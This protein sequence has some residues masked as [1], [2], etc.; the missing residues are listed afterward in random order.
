MRPSSPQQPARIVHS[1]T[2]CGAA[3]APGAHGQVNQDPLAAG[4]GVPRSPRRSGPAAKGGGR[5]RRCRAR[6]MFNHA[7]ASLQPLRAAWKSC[8]R[9][10]GW[11]G[12]RVACGPRGGI[13]SCASAAAA[14]AGGQKTQPEAEQR[15]CAC[16]HV[17]LVQD[18]AQ[19]H[20]WQGEGRS[21]LQHIYYRP[22]VL[23]FVSTEFSTYVLF[24]RLRQTPPN[25]VPSWTATCC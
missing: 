18:K 5:A 9:G 24:S 16:A 15:C 23:N 13:S 22:I 2:P 3:C 6:P 11:G 10:A 4:P 20:A 14:G 21:G 17:T 7:R 25:G 8:A 1:S 12:L 19:L